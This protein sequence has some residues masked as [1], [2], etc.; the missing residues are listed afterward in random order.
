MCARERRTGFQKILIKILFISI[1]FQVFT[2]IQ[3][4]TV[5]FRPE[6]INKYGKNQLIEPN[7]LTKLAL[8]SLLKNYQILFFQAYTWFCKKYNILSC[9]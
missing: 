7:P 1:L 8:S 2:L 5:Q 4:F 9:L 3:R 6:K